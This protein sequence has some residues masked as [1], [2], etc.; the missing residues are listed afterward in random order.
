MTI[1]KPV[2]EF[3]LLNVVVLITGLVVLTA[4]AVADWRIPQEQIWKDRR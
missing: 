1:I 2:L 4:A 3:G